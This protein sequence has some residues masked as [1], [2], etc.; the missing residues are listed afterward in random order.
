MGRCVESD[1]GY[2]DRHCDFRVITREN[3]SWRGVG[4]Y[5]HQVE[6]VRVAIS[7]LV[8]VYWFGRAFA[9]YSAAT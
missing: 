1:P 9:A 8:D 7:L 3:V 2:V 5:G 6:E 4:E